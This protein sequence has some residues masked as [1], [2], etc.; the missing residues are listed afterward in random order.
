MFSL[1]SF[2]FFTLL[3]PKNIEREIERRSTELWRHIP[4]IIYQRS[5]RYKVLCE[6][7][8]PY[9]ASFALELPAHLKIILRIE[10]EG[11]ELSIR[12]E[13]SDV[14]ARGTAGRTLLTSRTGFCEHESGVHEN[15]GRQ[16]E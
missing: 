7:H 2:F 12:A 9:A 11:L 6:H 3:L 13:L 16:D 10:R 1:Y 14:R 8:Q 5:Q 4:P 15:R